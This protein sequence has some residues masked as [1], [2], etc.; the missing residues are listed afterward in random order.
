MLV[1]CCPGGALVKLCFP[2]ERR[3]GE[4][5]PGETSRDSAKL[6]YTLYRGHGS[7]SGLDS[8][9]IPHLGE[10]QALGVTEKRTGNR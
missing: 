1:L 2:A 5:D 3:E 4:M 7:Y 6:H 8:K 9:K 10:H